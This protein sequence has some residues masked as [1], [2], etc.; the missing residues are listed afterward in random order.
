MGAQHPY[1]VNSPRAGGLYQL[2]PHCE[3]NNLLILDNAHKAQL[4]T[5]LVEQRRLGIE[6]PVVT[7]D[8]ITKTKAANNLRA[9][10]RADRVLQFLAERTQIL[11][12]P[13]LIVF[14]QEGKLLPGMET[15]LE[16]LAHS[17][18]IERKDLT[19]LFD[20]LVEKKL[21]KISASGRKDEYELTLTVDGYDRARDSG[22]KQVQS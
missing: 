1:E 10:E 3:N 18:S 12:T 22:E 9:S 15:C 13:V 14:L 20:D 16:L 6:A 4:T 8:I 19:F 2:D 21:M 11:G 5:W 17:E 7:G